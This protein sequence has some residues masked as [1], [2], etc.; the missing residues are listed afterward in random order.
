MT[1]VLTA[2]AM[3]GV[4]RRMAGAAAGRMSRL[5]A[6]VGLMVALNACAIPPVVSVAKLAAD[7]VLFAS[8]GKTSTDHGLSM[9][10]GKDCETFRM[11]EQQ[12]ICQEVV[13]AQA[14]AVPAEVERDR[15]AV[16]VL[17][18][19]APA[20]TDTRRALADQ[21]LA[22]AF[23][24]PASANGEPVVTTAALPRSIDP[25]SARVAARKD[26]RP[27]ARVAA[28]AP[29]RVV[30]ARPGLIKIA[31]PPLSQVTKAALRGTASKAKAAVSQPAAQAGIQPA[32]PD[33][34]AASGR[35]GAM[36]R[37][38]LLL[39]QAFRLDGGG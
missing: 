38:G 27:V 23:L 5:A 8:T 6:A 39:K 24:P 33:V 18:L 25:A 14:E 15:A 10:T 35:A 12:D 4:A 3:M 31:P 1:L 22:Q 16:D 21:A 20:G 29:S 37:I 32:P 2:V 17:V 30:A 19:T 36:E 9:V 26:D 34:G 7:G 13:L 28:A 11:L